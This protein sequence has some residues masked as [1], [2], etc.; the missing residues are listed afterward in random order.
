MARINLLPW[1]EERRKKLKIQFGVI[2]ALSA[3]MGAGVLFLVDLRVQS[4]IEYQIA[5]SE[6]IQGETKKLEHQ[7]AE[8][9]S[10]EKKKKSL[11]ER[12]DIIQ[13][14]QGKRSLIVHQFDELVRTV[15]DGIYLTSFNKK[16]DKF[17]VLGIAENNNKVTN[18]LRNLDASSWYKTTTLT[19]LKARDKTENALQIFSL[20]MLEKLPDK[21]DVK[22]GT[23]QPAEVKPAD[24]SAARQS[25]PMPTMGNRNAMGNRSAVGNRNAGDK[26]KSTSKI[27]WRFL[28]NDS[29][30]F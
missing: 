25:F 16:A 3:V 10:M 24:A 11:K 19:E 28:D 15:P 12:M 7:I 21:A 8:I 1:R 13:G 5:R 14:L 9:D 22:K 6:Y 2:T 23:E 30:W 29:F 27:K 18:F 20:T 26:L 17:L 4:N